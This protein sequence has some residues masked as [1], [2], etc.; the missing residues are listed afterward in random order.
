MLGRCN[1][2]PH[3]PRVVATLP[4]PLLLRRH[5]P[6]LLL[7]FPPHAH[8]PS[9]LPSPSFS[10]SFRLRRSL[11]SPS[12]PPALCSSVAPY[13][14]PSTQ[15]DV[16][17]GSPRPLGRGLYSRTGR[18]EHA[19]LVNSPLAAVAQPRAGGRA[20]GVFNWILTHHE[21]TILVTV[22]FVSKRHERP[23]PCNPFPVRMQS[24]PACAQAHPSPLRVVLSQAR[25]QKE[26]LLRLRAFA[27]AAGVDSLIT[28][29]AAA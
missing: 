15:G 4:L 1:R 18:G 24:V 21:P 10:H 16:A 17:R 22:H 23:R 7:R 5:R 27:S 3:A 12:S 25:G 29:R 28:L 20:A 14:T 6:C 2:S 19:L 9:S 11:N 8:A 26:S 13:S